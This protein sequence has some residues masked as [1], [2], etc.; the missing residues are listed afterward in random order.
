MSQ[1]DFYLQ[2]KQDEFSES[3]TT[4]LDYGLKQETSPTFAMEK[5]EVIATTTLEST[6]GTKVTPS[7]RN[8]LDL[9]REEKYATVEFPPDNKETISND[10]SIISGD[11]TPIISSLKILEAELTSR[12]KDL[13]PFWNT[14][15]RERSNKLWLPTK[16]DCVVSDLT[17]LNGSL[18][19]FPQGKSWFSTRVTAPPNKKLLRTFFR[20]STCSQ[21]RSTVS[22]NTNSRLNRSLDP[23]TQKLSL[24]TSCGVKSM[25]VRVYPTPKQK[26]ILKSWFGVFR[27]FY[28][29][30][31][32]YTTENQV[33]EFRKVRNNMRTNS[34][35]TLPQWCETDIPPRIIAGAIS[36][37]CKA[38]KTCFS[39]RGSGL[40][41]GFK[42]HYKTK[43][44]RS[45]CIYLEKSCFSKKGILPK[46]KFG[47]LKGVYHHKQVLLEDITIDHDCRLTATGGKYYLHVPTGSF[48]EP[49]SHASGVISLDS[50]IRTFQTG[51]SP[52][53]YTVELGVDCVEKF[54]PQLQKIDRLTAVASSCN[55]KKRKKLFSTI[56]RINS[57][58][59][60][61]IDDLHWKTIN[62]LTRNYSTIVVSDFKTA[63][64]FTNKKLNRGSKRTMALL[65]HYL[66]RLRLT[67]KCKQRGNEL[68]YVDESYTSKTCTCCGQLNNQLGSNKVFNCK[69][70]GLEIDRDINGARNILIKNWTDVSRPVELHTG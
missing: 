66:F 56:K 50:G 16:T 51:Y 12:G 9:P 32:D 11:A 67:E 59:R 10:K 63:G 34:K 21:P 65:G 70:C 24:Q 61:K 47:I 29:R 2:N 37:C 49:R 26:L 36:D 30:T 15:S 35:F 5:R 48:T 55:K 62:F 42:L 69:Y 68:F 53:N 31:I 39:Q 19:S 58:I 64:L 43:K 28:N 60:N 45:Q 44:D 57:T 33:Y 54:K 25:T 22:E 6:S 3:K 20:S 52:E 7:L 38:Y 13:K 41:D 4:P 40:I 17:S 1:L 18:K 27:W 23:N 46:Y 8:E 14:Q